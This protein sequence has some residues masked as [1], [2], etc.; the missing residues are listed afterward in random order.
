MGH[1]GFKGWGPGSQVLGLGTQTPSPHLELTPPHQERALQSLL[2]RKEG[3]KEPI[4]VELAAACP[5]C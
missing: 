3:A 2:G 1:G 5:L 4:P